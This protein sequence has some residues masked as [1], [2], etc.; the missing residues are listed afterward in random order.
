MN[1]IEVHFVGGMWSMYAEQKSILVEKSEGKIYLI[2][3]SE[4]N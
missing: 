1:L 4:V 2:F 3:F